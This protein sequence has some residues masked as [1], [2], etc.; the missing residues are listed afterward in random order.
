[1]KKNIFLIIAFM[2]SMSL[3]TAQNYVNLSFTAKMQGDSFQ[4]L[5]SVKILNVTRGW[6]ETIYYPDTILQLTN[7]V[8]IAEA[9]NIGFWVYQNMPNPFE[10]STEVKVQLPMDENITLTLYDVSGKQY[11]FYSGNL[12]SGLHT[13]TLQV[14]VAQMYI[15]HV[16]T[17]QGEQNI[18]L[19]A[20]KGSDVCQLSYAHAVSYTN[21]S[22][23]QKAE[24]DKEYQSND[25]MQFI[26]YT[27]H[28]NFKQVRQINVLQAG[29]DANY[30]FDYVAGYAVGDV[31]YDDHGLVEG[32]VCWIADTVFTDKEK[33]YGSRGK[34]ISLNESDTGLMY[35]TINRPTHALDS[36]DGRIN[37][38]IH[39][40]LRSD[41]SQYLFKERIE[42]AKWC[43]DQGEGWYFPAKYE[44]TTVLENIETLNTRLQDLG[45]TIISRLEVGSDRGYYWTSTEVPGGVFGNH[46]NA[47]VV[48]T[49]Q[50]GGIGYA[51]IPLYVKFNVRGMKWFGE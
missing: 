3:S 15:L 43:V 10:V 35:G 5:D 39:M 12:T 41:T 19:L 7:S 51:T 49:W 34:I 20:T 47:Y 44:M 13:F 9:E 27:T 17:L 22:K 37:T 26:G 14:R 23:L 38:A 11:A 46:C 30:T 25:S 36:V 8:G 21:V 28:H 33:P 48:N 16:K 2:A 6:E 29:S 24:T 50:N 31:Y 40:A 32:V 42:A 18:K 4:A 45:A 1:M